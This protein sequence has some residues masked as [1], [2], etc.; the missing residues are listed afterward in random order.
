MKKISFSNIV[1]S[2]FGFTPK[3]SLEQT[4][5]S[6]VLTIKN[7][8]DSF[9]KL[10]KNNLDFG[11][12]VKSP[13]EE[14]FFLKNGDF[15]IEKIYKNAEYPAILGNQTLAGTNLTYN[16]DKKIL[17]SS[18][19]DEEAKYTEDVIKDLITAEMYGGRGGWTGD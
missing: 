4:I 2:V 6:Y 5:R 1:E 15:N 8:K 7:S 11:L 3:Q 9:K 17:L 13:T 18:L 12:V 16:P 10:P 19:S 14:I